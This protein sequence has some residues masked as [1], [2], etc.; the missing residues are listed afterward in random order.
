M[1]EQGI[2]GCGVTLE[3]YEALRDVQATVREYGNPIIFRL[4]QEGNITRDEYQSIASRPSD[5]SPGPLYMN[6][7]GMN[8]NPTERQL[9]KVGLR[10]KGDLILKTSMMDWM[11]AAVSFD[12]IDITRCTVD[13]LA[14]PGDLAGATY[15]VKDKSRTNGFALGF[16]YI[17]FSLSRRG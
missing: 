4:R 8:Y 9:E 17:A 12:E 11:D 16:L 15:E 2:S 10:E 1:M 7:I 3:F 14:F 5:L 6:A 13:V